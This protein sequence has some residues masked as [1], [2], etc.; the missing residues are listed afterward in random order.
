MFRQRNNFKLDSLSSLL[1]TLTLPSCP[2]ANNLCQNSALNKDFVQHFVQNG[3]F[4][5][6]QVC[7]RL[8]MFHLVINVCITKF[9][10][11]L[12]SIIGVTYLKHLS[13][14]SINSWISNS[15]RIAERVLITPGPN[16]KR[17][18]QKKCAWLREGLLKLKNPV[19]RTIGMVKFNW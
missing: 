8:F 4:V 12:W 9:W 14:L 15:T 10:F 7:S 6:L 3:K 5:I 13:L 11:L 17:L 19:M 16:W 18:V 1:L 2:S